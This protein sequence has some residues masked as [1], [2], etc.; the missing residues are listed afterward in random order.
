MKNEREFVGTLMGFDDYVSEYKLSLSLPDHCPFS[1][2]WG[3]GRTDG[4]DMV[5]KDVKE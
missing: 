2:S 5:L 1:I 3:N 4:T